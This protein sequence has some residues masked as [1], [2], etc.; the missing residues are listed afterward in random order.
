LQAGLLPFSGNLSRA[1]SASACGSRASVSRKIRWATTPPRASQTA[2][3]SLHQDG[4]PGASPPP[5][6]G[7][8]ARR[9]ASIS[10]APG[11]DVTLTANTAAYS[12]RKISSREK[13]R[14]W[15]ARNLT[16]AGSLTPTPS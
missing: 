3:P 4:L 6:P 12:S 5:E 15:A 7:L 16:L 1:R 14:T 8:R 13:S 2:A 9:A 10:I 11:G